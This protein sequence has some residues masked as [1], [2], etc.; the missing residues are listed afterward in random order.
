[1]KH[2]SG[3]MEDQDSIFSMEDSTSSLDLDSDDIGG[4]IGGGGPSTS[5]TSMSTSLS[6]Q[7]KRGGVGGGIFDQIPHM[8]SSR[9]TGN[10]SPTMMERKSSTVTRGNQG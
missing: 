4:G 3:T 7:L 10:S 5:S 8:K 1:M 9:D 6:A 2:D